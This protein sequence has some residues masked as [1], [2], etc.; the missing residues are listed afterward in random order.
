MNSLQT[1]PSAPGQGS[2]TKVPRFNA[3]FR[4][5]GGYRVLIYLMPSCARKCYLPAQCSSR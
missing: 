5:E 3:M 2:P 1:G 4:S